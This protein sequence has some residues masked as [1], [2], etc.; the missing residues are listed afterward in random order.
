MARDA[1]FQIVKRAADSWEV[2]YWV[3]IDCPD[4]VEADS[5]EVV[6]R[7]ALDIFDDR[8]YI[9]RPIWGRGAKTCEWHRMPKL[10][11]TWNAAIR[12]VTNPPE[13]D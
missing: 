2:F 1:R 3:K 7:V 6:A 13:K 12:D 8:Y 5:Y 10:Y 4:G 9:E 11:L